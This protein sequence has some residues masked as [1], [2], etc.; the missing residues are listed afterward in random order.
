MARSTQI[1]S[2]VFGSKA[3]VPMGSA[4]MA[5]KASSVIAILTIRHAVRRALCCGRRD[6]AEIDVAGP[7]AMQPVAALQIVQPLSERGGV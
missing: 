5:S 4:T 6:C 3:T 2:A 7:V 1:R